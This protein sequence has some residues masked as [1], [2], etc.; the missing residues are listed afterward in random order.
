M[1]KFLPYLFILFTITAWMACSP[2]TAPSTTERPALKTDQLPDIIALGSCNDE[3]RKQPLWSAIIDQQPDLWLWLGDNIYADTDDPKVFRQ[4]YDKQ[5]ANPGYQ[6]LMHEVPMMGVWDDHDYGLNDGGK[7]YTAKELSKK[8][9]LRFLGVPKSD[10]VW[11][12]SG[13]YQSKRFSRDGKSLRIILLDA[14]WFRDKLLRKDG[15]CQPNE[16]GDILGEEQWQWLE[17]ELSGDDDLVIIGSG[18][19]FLPVDHPYEKWANFPQ[20]RKRLFDMIDNSKAGQVVLVSG[21]RHLAEVSKIETP[22]GKELWELTTSGLTHSYR[23]EPKEKN[24]YRVGPVI[25]K[26]NFG[27]IRIDWGLEQPGVE[28]EIRGEN[29]ILYHQI[30][31]GS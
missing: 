3:D 30:P 11:D 24:R 21:D 29:S 7:E 16:T 25:P 26:L 4:K 19:Q 31:T 17:R 9:M 2:K 12:H 8:E 1:K 18:I 13:S 23:G 27:V 6:A 10:P 28:L 15:V 14:R 5:L 22:G 20:A